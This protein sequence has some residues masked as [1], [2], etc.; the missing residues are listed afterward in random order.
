MKKKPPDKTTREHKI[1]LYYTKIFLSKKIKD[2]N[3]NCA[4]HCYLKIFKSK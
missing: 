4:L 1:I 3:I 2:K